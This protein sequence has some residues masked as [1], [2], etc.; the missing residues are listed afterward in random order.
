MSGII[1]TVGSKSGIIGTTEMDYEEGLWTPTA[2][3]GGGVGGS[4]TSW[5]TAKYTK[6][7]R[8]VS[9]RTR[10]YGGG[11]ATGADSGSTAAGDTFTIGN[12][13]F[14]AADMYDVHGVAGGRSHIA[15]GTMY[16]STT[17][18]KFEIVYT[19]SSYARQHVQ[20]IFQINYYTAS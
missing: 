4:G 15:W 14:T 20:Y 2:T 7:G 8:F 9:M 3:Y 11:G 5:D 12:F 16:S 18:F 6:I 10:Y 1:D 19:T 13:P 17:A